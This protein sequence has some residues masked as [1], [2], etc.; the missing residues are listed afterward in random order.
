MINLLRKLHLVIVY[1]WIL[2]VFILFLPF[3]WL[4]TRKPRYYSLL[5]K[6]RTVH[7]YLSLYLSGIFVCIRYEKRL[8]KHKSYIICSNHSSS[9]DIFLSCMVARGEYHFMG[10]EELLKNPITAMFFKTIDVA[11]NRKSKISSFKAFKRVSENLDNGMSLIIFPEG[12]IGNHYP[13]RLEE[14]KNGPFRLAIDKNIEIV[15]V[16]I[17]NIWELFWDSGFKYGSRPGIVD[18]IVHE[19]IKTTNFTPENEDELKAEV[20]Q[21]IKSKLSYE[22]RQRNSLQSGRFG[23]N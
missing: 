10:K 6:F 14:F 2:L 16:S 23:K 4:F 12:K 1:F 18:L 19:P 5:N 22:Y 11:V 15:P 20:Y 7:S 21:K 9:L 3:Y 17:P 8:D 13:P